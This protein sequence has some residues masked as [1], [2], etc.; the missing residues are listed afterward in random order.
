MVVNNPLTISEDFR[1][2]N[3]ALIRNLTDVKEELSY[4]LNILDYTS[5]GLK[6]GVG[7]A[8]K[9]GMSYAIAKFLNDPKDR[10]ISLD[11][12]CVVG[13]NYIQTLFKHPLKGSAFTMYFEHVLNSENILFYE[14]YLRYLRWGLKLAGSPF[15]YYS[16]GSCLGTTVESYQKS[17]GM[18]SK[19]ATED[20]HFLN[21]LRKLGSVDYWVD[22]WVRPSSRVS[23]RVTLGTGYFLFL[24]KHDFEKAF[25]KL[26]IPNVRHFSVLKEILKLFS[27]YDGQHSL[28]DQFEKIQQTTLY[29]DL[30]ERKVIEKIHHIFDS[31]TNSKNYGSRLMEVV[32]AL[33]TLRILRFLWERDKVPMTKDIFMACA[34]ELWST[35]LSPQELLMEIRKREKEQI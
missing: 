32:D 13:D 3:L 23:E 30:H 18:V 19:S 21:K 27:Q 22:T 2:D 1:K 20:F 8:R 10:L 26:M 6:N 9:I 14:L 17:G 34:N 24:A 29:K 5:P 31:T 7:E 35:N 28:R 12:D 11:A 4:P 25:Q 33:E 15:D 16:V